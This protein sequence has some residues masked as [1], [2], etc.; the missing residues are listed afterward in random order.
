[1]ADVTILMAV[2]NG[3]KYIKQAI[4]SILKQTFGNFELL[5]INDGSTDNS[6]NIIDSFKDSRIRSVQQKRNLGTADSLNHGLKLIN[7]KYTRRHDADDISHPSM[8]DAQIDFLKNHPE[9]Q[10]VGT[11]IAHMT[12]SGKIAK[13]VCHPSL[14][15]FREGENHLLVSRKMFEPYS[16]IIHG[17]VMGLTSIFKEM[18]GYRNFFIT[19]EDNDLWLRIIEKYQFAV[20]KDIYYYYRLN[21]TSIT[22]VHQDS[23]QFYW[24]VCLKFA[25]ERAIIG[26]DAIQ[27]GEF[28]PNFNLETYNVINNTSPGK[29]FREGILYYDYLVSLNAKDLKSVIKNIKIALRDGWKLKLTYLAILTPLVGKNLI[30]KGVKLKKLLKLF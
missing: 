28:I 11:R 22:K 21:E 8:L 7:T 1:M 12:E 13:D 10:F 27:R 18:G 9:V 26:S 17:T 29:N 5:I 30:N 6:Q 25:D 4:D 20:L 15:Y 2:Y 16:P 24:N 3:E 23:V 19:S 14:K